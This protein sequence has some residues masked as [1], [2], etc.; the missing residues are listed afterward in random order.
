MNQTVIAV[1][2]EQIQFLYT[3]LVGLPFSY[4]VDSSIFLLSAEFESLE[5]IHI[6]AL[7]LIF[8]LKGKQIY[9]LVVHDLKLLDNFSI[10]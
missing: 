6:A 9:P 2:H 7:G 5:S 4:T 10:S 1:N 8:I 3:L